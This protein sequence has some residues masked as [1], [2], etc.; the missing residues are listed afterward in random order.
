MRMAAGSHCL[1]C[2]MDVEEGT[3]NVLCGKSGCGKS[4]LLKI[5]QGILEPDSGSVVIGPE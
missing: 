4:T 1:M 5:M 2:H 3:L